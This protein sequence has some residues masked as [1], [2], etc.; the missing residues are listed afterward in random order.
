MQQTGR[1]RRG[2]FELDPNR[3]RQFATGLSAHR[4]AIF[5]HHGSLADVEASAS[6]LDWTR[7]SLLL[8]WRIFWVDAWLFSQRSHGQ[9]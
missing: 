8:I 5:E 7:A 4:S 3:P 6:S 1:A 2:G 9:A